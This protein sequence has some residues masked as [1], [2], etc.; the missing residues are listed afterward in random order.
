[1]ENKIKAV[2]NAQV[3]KVIDFIIFTLLWPIVY[4]I[5]L[6]NYI[7]NSETFTMF[8]VPQSLILPYF[9]IAGI[10]TIPYALVTLFLGTLKIYGYFLKR[11]EAQ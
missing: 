2:F 10:V 6:V 5:M 1:M 9:I 7:Q 11:K 4:I 8:L 3:L